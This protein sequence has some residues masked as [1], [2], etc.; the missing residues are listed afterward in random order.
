MRHAPELIAA[1]A[2]IGAGLLGGWAVAAGLLI[3]T[4]GIAIFYGPA[5]PARGLLRVWA[6]V[7]VLCAVLVMSFMARQPDCAPDDEACF[8]RPR[9]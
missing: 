4:A 7:A 2:L 5:F 6:V 3:T 1:A 8:S 9:P